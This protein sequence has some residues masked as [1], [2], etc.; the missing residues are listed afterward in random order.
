MAR[1]RWQTIR[2][3]V[4]M[5]PPVYG[6]Y[7]NQPW[8]RVVLP[9]EPIPYVDGPTAAIALPGVGRALAIYSALIKQMPLDRLRGTEILSRTR[10]LESPDPLSTL[11]AFTGGHVEDYLLHGNAVS[12][13]NRW[14]EGLPSSCSWLPAELTSAWADRDGPHYQHDGEEIDPRNVI[15]VRRGLDRRNRLRGVGV[16]EQ[17]I[18]ALDRIAREEGYSASQLT[19]A[20]VPSVAIITPD[21]N[22]SPTEA[23][24]AGDDWLEKY[25]GV[26]RRPGI[27]PDGTKVIPLSWSP[28]DA[29]LVEAR[30]LS[31]TDTA[32]MFNLDGYYLGAGAPSHTYRS[33][34]PMY[35]N[36]LRMSIESVL[37]DLEAV[38][39]AWWTPRG[40]RVRF[41]RAPVLRD[42]LA[43][44]V[45]ML[46]GA[47]AARGEDNRPLMTWAEAREYM[48][49]P[50]EGIPIP[51]PP[52]APPAPAEEEADDDADDEEGT[53]EP[54][55]T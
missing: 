24:V 35:L 54:E 48:H 53:D 21:P 9:N 50:T 6:A 22:L 55:Q 7:A 11:P 25:G 29:Q 14:S 15:H 26:G 44:T 49:L 10:L 30:K 52:P 3:T 13:V 51:D 40:Q 27:F 2:R 18:D 16:V 5:P 17:H 41:D 23:K 45:A 43:S 42:D 19:T 38:W 8:N 4:L 37:V 39:S 47:M 12:Y 32:N 20:A 34:G 1:R 46:A 31:L 28:T 33:P 36:L